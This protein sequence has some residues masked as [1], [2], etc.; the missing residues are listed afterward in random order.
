[1]RVLKYLAAAALLLSVLVAAVG[2]LQ[3][4]GEDI[5]LQLA[6][7]GYM[8]D[9]FN[10]GVLDQFEKDH[11]GIRVELVSS[12][13]QVMTIS[14]GSSAGRGDIED[15]LDAREAYAQSA[16]VLAVGSA[17]LTPEVTRA[18]YF[19]DLAPLIN[20]DP[21]LNSADFYTAVWQS[22]QWDGGAWALPVSAD[23]ILLFYDPAAFDAAGLPYPNTWQSFEDV[24]H[25]IRT[26]TQL[27]PDGTV[28]SLGFR[29]EQG[30]LNL[31]LRSLLDQ[32]VY[33]ESVSP[34]VPRFDLPALQ[35]VLTGWAQMQADGLFNP[36]RTD[37]DL[38]PTLFDAPLTLSRSAFGFDVPDAAPKLPALLP[39][40]Y[41]GLDVNGFA[42]SSGTQHPEAAYELAKYLTTSAQVATSFIGG[43]PARRDVMAETVNNG[44]LVGRDAEAS[45][46]LAALIPTALDQAFPVGETRF[47]EYL[48]QAIDAMV[49]DGLD[50]SQALQQVEDTALARL[51][52]ASAR[53]DA[54]PIAVATPVPT[55]ELAPGEIALK[56]GVSSFMSPLPNQDRWDAFVDDFVARDPE[57]GDV[58]LE[59][60]RVGS[61]ADMAQRYDCF[62]A[63]GNVVPTAD[64]SLLR[65]LDPLLSADPTFDPGGM[66]NGVMQQVQR[67]G[68]TWGLPVTIQP[69]AMRYNSDVFAQAGALTPVDGWTAEEF[70]Y[71]LEVLKTITGDAEP[72]VPRSSGNT[73]L[74]M[75]IAA[76]GGLPLDYSTTP[77]TIN[78]TDPATVEAIRRVLDLAR[79]GYIDY[80]ELA[81]TG[82]AV[83]ISVVEGGATP[84]Y[85]ETL[86]GIGSIGGLGGGG[87]VAI[88]SS[89]G[90]GD[91]AGAPAQPQ[92][93]DPLVTFPHGS[94]YTPMSYDISAAYISANTASVEACYRFISELS[95]RPDL[96]TE[97]PARH[98]LINS[99]DIASIQGQETAQFYQTM[100]ALLQSPNTVLF[101]T[102][103]S[104]NPATAGDTL[105]PFWLNRAFD[106]YIM[107]DADLETELVAAEQF[108]KDFQTCAAAI[109][110]YDAATDDYGQYFEA[111]ANC[112]VQV[113]PSTAS[114]FGS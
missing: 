91:E 3:A 38:S 77:P 47:T 69:L 10:A 79:D 85:T 26:L 12:G 73:Y 46:E 94:V 72:F 114:Y 59:S 112:A 39:G 78:F 93:V 49:N 24:E 81:S 110:P 113:D 105:L 16:D 52:A 45:P 102:G 8:E 18:G 74:L 108:T 98:S 106:H 99:S 104:F 67:D 107:E 33:D 61:L 30:A 71:A 40:G 68:Q 51:S 87:M 9:M 95:R 14:F 7:P 27:K 31:L 90:S 11:P 89:A 62:Y 35:D 76:Y 43:T 17:D 88:A 96:L 13:G 55:V 54:G 58:Q 15:V 53:R 109:A 75:L 80:S 50:A 20:S 70:E 2:P 22:F 37:G 92:T 84:L 21:N 1:M 66:V 48:P 5:V 29:D 23:P 97:M 19:L 82:N 32:G 56:V 36:P 111:F 103:L 100:E 60:G 83:T 65:S 25:A 86:H 42:V 44:P 101:P 6:I 34:S 41:A 63:S 64:L 4:Q 57:V 28:E